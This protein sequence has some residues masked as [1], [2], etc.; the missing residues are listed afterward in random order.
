MYLD[1]CSSALLSFVER[2]LKNKKKT[3]MESKDLVYIMFYKIKIKTDILHSSSL[4]SVH[5][6]KSGRV[7]IFSF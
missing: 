2:K 7:N 3:I 1:L 5:T 6:A 4:V